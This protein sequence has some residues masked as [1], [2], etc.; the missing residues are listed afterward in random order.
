MN[1]VKAIKYHTGAIAL[2]RLLSRRVR[3]LIR[4]FFYALV[5]TLVSYM[6]VGHYF[7]LPYLAVATG[8]ALMTGALLGFLI[9]FEAYYN[10]YYFFGLNSIIGLDDRKATGC[11]YEVAQSLYGDLGDITAAFL[12]SELGKE[13]ALRV[14]LLPS[15]IEA[16][17]REVRTPVAA[18]AISI[19]DFLIFRLETLALTL[20]QR[21][22]AF[23]TFLRSEGVQSEDLLGATR[24]V[25]G[26]V[27]AKKR[28]VRWWSK[29]NLSKTQSFGREW[30][31]GQTYQLEQYVKDIRTSA[32]FSTLAN[33]AAYAKEN[34]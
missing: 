29:D 27:R 8:S 34:C 13:I 5:C 26:R 11:S 19:D 31:Y 30:A 32:V 33:N 14:G 20:L 10:T 7:L 15:D 3:H 24:W 22:P 1:L 21:D 9:L 6:I 2:D 12:Q 4:V 25:A 16:F 28:S 18:Q 23:E 17:L